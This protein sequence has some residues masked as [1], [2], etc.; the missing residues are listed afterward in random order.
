MMKIALVVVA[1]L[2]FSSAFTVRDLSCQTCK[3]PSFQDKEFYLP[4][5]SIDVHGNKVTHPT[6]CGAVC[7]QDAT[8]TPGSCDRC[9]EK[10]SKVFTPVCSVNQKV[11]FANP[12]YAVCA[13]LTDLV[14]QVIPGIVNPVPAIPYGAATEGYTKC[15]NLKNMERL[16]YVYIPD[17]YKLF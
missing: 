12:C 4:Y 16:L 17:M 6:Y 14:G 3:A 15:R 1:C 13:G 10:C 5:C 9:E 11:L 8:F 2:S 7:V